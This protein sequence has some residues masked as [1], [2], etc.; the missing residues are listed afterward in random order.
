VVWDG[1]VWDG[2]V[3]D[4]YLGSKSHCK[5]TACVKEEWHSQ[6]DVGGRDNEILC[7]KARTEGLERALRSAQ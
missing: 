7:S 5:N 2:V 3:W 4:G 6:R 1:V